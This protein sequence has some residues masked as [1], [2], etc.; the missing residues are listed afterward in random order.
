MK[1]LVISLLY[2]EYTIAPFPGIFCSLDQTICYVESDSVTPY[3]VKVIT[4]T[5][6]EK[7]AVGTVQSIEDLEFVHMQV[8]G[9]SFHSAFQD[10]Y[11]HLD[12]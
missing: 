5:H 8:P 7:S 2:F 9:V 1:A 3:P 10:F 11:R 12:S 4:L 6:F